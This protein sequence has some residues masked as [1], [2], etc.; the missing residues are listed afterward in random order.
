MYTEKTSLC[1][2]FCLSKIKCKYICQSAVVDFANVNTSVHTCKCTAPRIDV[3]VFLTVISIG[4]ADIVA[5]IA[6]HLNV[7][8]EIQCKY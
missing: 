1:I 8:H 5:K 6:K 4:T 7:R 3:K 2:S